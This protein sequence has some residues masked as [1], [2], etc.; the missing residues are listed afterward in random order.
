MIKVTESNGK[1]RKYIDSRMRIVVS[2]HGVLTIRDR[3]GDTIKAYPE[4]MWT[5]AEVV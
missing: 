1:V 5:D 2:T 4:G 3:R